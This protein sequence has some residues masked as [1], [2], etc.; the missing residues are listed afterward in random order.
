MVEHMETGL[1]KAGARQQLLI[2]LGR[3]T[4]G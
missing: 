4:G 3:H 1:T 2:A